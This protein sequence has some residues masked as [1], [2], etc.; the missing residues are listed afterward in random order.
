MVVAA[1]FLAIVAGVRRV[2]FNLRNASDLR[3]RRGHHRESAVAQGGPAT[4]GNRVAGLFT[5]V[6]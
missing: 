6:L 1:A 5:F 2:A 4:I 3:R